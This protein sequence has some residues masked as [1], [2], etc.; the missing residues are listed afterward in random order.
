MLIV[1]SAFLGRLRSAAWRLA[2]P[3]SAS[4]LATGM[5]LAAPEQA[6]LLDIAQPLVPSALVA[7]DR[8]F[9]GNGPVVTT[10]VTLEITPDRSGIDAVVYFQAKETK[11]DWSETRETFRR[12]VFRANNGQRVVRIADPAMSEVR[13]T[14][15]PGGIQF[16]FPG[17]DWAVLFDVLRQLIEQGETYFGEI[18][19]PEQFPCETVE[20]CGQMLRAGVLRLASDNHVHVLP[21]SNG[22][23]V[24]TFLI[25]G[26]TGGDDISTDKNPK[27]DTRIQGI[28]FKEIAVEL[29]PP[30]VPAAHRP[31][32]RPAPASG[33]GVGSASGALTGGAA[34]TTTALGAMDRDTDRYGG[35]YRNFA[36]RRSD[37]GLC[38][39]ACNAESGCSAWSAWTPPASSGQPAHCWLKSSAPA[40]RPAPGFTSGLITNQAISIKPPV[41]VLR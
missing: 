16:G 1:P 15:V 4:V 30:G 7:G 8:E 23:P 9:D 33:S 14:S 37:A 36:L 5:A 3:A 25:V 40:R 21:P 35:D 18:D 2:L 39:Q 11:H 19:I 12:P 28:V 38:Q 6:R 22:G 34:T 26:D 10:R 29:D 32:P 27:D 13:F 24:A 20:E 17:E 31:S 41:S